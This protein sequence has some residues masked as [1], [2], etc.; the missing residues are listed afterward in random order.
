[1]AATARLH[2]QTWPHPQEMAA[3]AR[4]HFQPWRGTTAP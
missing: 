2:F 4:L 3:T 1:M